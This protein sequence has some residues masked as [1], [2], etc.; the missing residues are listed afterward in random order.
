MVKI[1]K[2][3]KTQE[4][5]VVNILKK[6]GFTEIPKS[7]IEKEPYKTIYALPECF[8]DDSRTARYK[9]KE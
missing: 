4:E 3:R 5:E 7:E 2:V 9:A 8:Q 6:S 1:R